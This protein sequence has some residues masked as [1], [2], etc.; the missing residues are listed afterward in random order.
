MAF[1]AAT[2]HDYI[3]SS[4]AL[5]E[6]ILAFLPSA[7]LAPFQTSHSDATATRGS[8][9]LLFTLSRKVSLSSAAVAA[10]VGAMAASAAPKGKWDTKDNRFSKQ[11]IKVAIAACSPHRRLRLFALAQGIYV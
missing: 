9:V 8:Y 10:I 4:P 3:A 2:M 5:D 6:G 11:F 7:L 1:N